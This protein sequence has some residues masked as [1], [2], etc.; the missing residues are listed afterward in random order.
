MPISPILMRRKLD[1]VA[2]FVDHIL[3][4]RMHFIA[5]CVAIRRMLLLYWRLIIARCV[6]VG[7]CR[8]VLG[9]L[10]RKRQGSR[11]GIDI[12]STTYYSIKLELW[13]IEY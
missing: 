6:Q 4:L 11:V 13:L 5:T 12:S 8:S 10:N 3:T 9:M 1:I 7:K 2:V